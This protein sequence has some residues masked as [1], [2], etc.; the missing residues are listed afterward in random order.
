MRRTAT[1]TRIAAV[2]ETWRRQLTLEKRHTGKASR[3]EAVVRARCRLLQRM[4]DE[5]CTVP[6]LAA[7][8]SLAMFVSGIR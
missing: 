6:Q 3:S 8:A 4:M 5:L 7:S 2:V 1:D